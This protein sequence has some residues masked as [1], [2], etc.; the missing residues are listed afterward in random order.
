[1][2][3][4][5]AQQDIHDTDVAQIADLLSAA[6]RQYVDCGAIPPGAWSSYEADM[7]Q[8]R[9]RIGQG[10]D[11]LVVLDTAHAHDAGHVHDKGESLHVWNGHKGRL[12]ACV[13]FCHDKPTSSDGSVVKFPDACAYIRYLG[14]HPNARGSRL[15][16]LLISKCMERAKTMG[17][18]YVVS[19]FLFCV[20][21][22][23]SIVSR[24]MHTARD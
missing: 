6:Y 2:G 3:V 11:L 17:K 4:I 12:V 15:G 24:E 19:C 16:E 14:V 22:E 7:R 9:S 18:Q 10:K 8:V 5:S 23:A 20:R 13:T 21:M 1:V